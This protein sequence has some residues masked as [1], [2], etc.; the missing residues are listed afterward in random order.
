[1]TSYIYIKVKENY[2]FS[3]NTCLSKVMLTLMVP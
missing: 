2:V 3:L 1:M